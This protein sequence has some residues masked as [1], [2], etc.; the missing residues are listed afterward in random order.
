MLREWNPEASFELVF[1]GFFYARRIW[2]IIAGL[3]MGCAEYSVGVARGLVRQ[4]E[5]SLSPEELMLT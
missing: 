2:P 4:S 5:F 3:G 1:A